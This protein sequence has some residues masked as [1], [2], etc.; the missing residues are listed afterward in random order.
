MTDQIPKALKQERGRAIQ[1]LESE[2]KQDYLKQ[3]VGE[4]LQLLVEKAN[5]DGMVS[6]TSCRYAQIRTLAPGAL[7]NSLVEVDVAG[8]EGDILVG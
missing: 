2:L 3:L 5:P 1:K 8:V 7:E 6:G 4:R